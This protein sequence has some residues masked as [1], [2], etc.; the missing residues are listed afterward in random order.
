MLFFSML[1]FVGIVTF[2]CCVLMFLFFNLVNDFG[3]AMNRGIFWINKG[4]VMHT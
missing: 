2:Y 1:S 3:I 4:G